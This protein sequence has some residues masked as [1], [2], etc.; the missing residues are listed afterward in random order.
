MVFYIVRYGEIALKGK[1]RGNFESILKNNIREYLKQRYSL[2]SKLFSVRGRIILDVQFDDKVD[3]DLDIDLRPVFGIVSYSEALKMPK[4]FDVIKDKCVE[5]FKLIK[6]DNKTFKIETHRL[7]KSFN[8]NS[9][10]I[11]KVIGAEIIEIFPEVNVKLKNPDITMG[12]EI[13]SDFAYVYSNLINCFGGLPLG[14]AGKIAVEFDNNNRSLLCCLLLMKRGSIIFLINNEFE[15]NPKTLDMLKLYNNY[16]PI[17]IINKEN[18]YKTIKEKDIDSIAYSQEYSDIEKTDNDSELLLLYPLALN[19]DKEVE[20][21][22]KK[23]EI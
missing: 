9:I 7:D 1:N 21:E 8:M 19:S 23:Y 14:S 6:K 4:N 13:H 22:L 16:N 15:N 12:I 18:I 3:S 5:V 20:E 10:E 17:R 2:N 11:N